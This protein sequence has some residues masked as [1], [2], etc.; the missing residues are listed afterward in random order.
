[1]KIITANVL[2]WLPSLFLV[3]NGQ[4]GSALPSTYP[5]AIGRNSAMKQE[6]EIAKNEWIER[7]DMIDAS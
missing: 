6:I 1:M 7:P 4:D 3:V 2:T 5:K